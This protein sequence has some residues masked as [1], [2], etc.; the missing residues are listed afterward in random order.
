MIGERPFLH[1]R[2]GLEARI[3]RSVF[4]RLVEEGVEQSND[5]IVYSDGCT[6]NLGSLVC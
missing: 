2:D 3:Q 1:V 6:F 4:Y 5:L